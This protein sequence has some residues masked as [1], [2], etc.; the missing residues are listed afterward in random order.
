MAC[1]QH[2]VC[3][4]WELHRFRKTFACWHHERNRVS[5]N[6]PREWLGHESLDVPLAH[7][8]AVPSRSSVQT[9]KLVTIPRRGPTS[10]T[11]PRIYAIDMQLIRF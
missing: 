6:T 1:K 4:E 11:R 2:P 3:G 8:K 7:L 10:A 9:T 5:V